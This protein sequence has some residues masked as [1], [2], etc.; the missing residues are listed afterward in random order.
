MSELKERPIFP[1]RRNPDHGAHWIVWQGMK[2][3]C[4]WFGKK[5]TITS[6][7]LGEE[8]ESTAVVD[9]AELISSASNFIPV[10][11]K[12]VASRVQV[13]IIYTDVLFGRRGERSYLARTQSAAKAALAVKY[14]RFLGKSIDIEWIGSSN[15]IIQF[16]E[17]EIYRAK[18]EDYDAEEQPC[19]RVED[20]DEPEEIIYEFPCPI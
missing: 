5:W 17:P 3:A 8:Y 15:E 6:K 2:T 14:Q 7:K 16:E 4:G 10:T 18:N 20:Y 1:I 9:I 12:K 11:T 13:E 19:T